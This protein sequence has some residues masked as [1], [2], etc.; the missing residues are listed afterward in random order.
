MNKTLRLFLKI[1]LVLAAVILGWNARNHAV[2]TLPVDYDEDDYIRAAQEYTGVFRSGNLINL[3]EYNYRPEH[4]PLA[5]IIFG[6]SLLTAPEKPLTP[7]RATTSSPDS[8]LSRDLLIPARTISALEGTLTVFFLALIN[9][10]AGVLLASHTFTIKYTSQVML[11][12]LPSLTSFLTILAYLRFKKTTRKYWLILSALFLGLTAASKYIYCL[13]G[14]AIL[15]DW[16]L[17]AYK[18]NQLKKSFFNAFGWGLISIIFFFVAN[19]YLWVDPLSRL[20]ESIFFHAAYSTTASEVQSAG[21]PIWQPFIWLSMSPKEWHPMVFR[22]APDVYISILAVLGFPRLWKKERLYILWLIVAILFLLAWPTK[23]PQYILVLTVP[24]SL[25]AAEGLY[26]VFAQPFQRWWKNRSTNQTTDIPPKNEINRAAKW[27]IPGL[28]AFTLLTIFPLIFQFAVSLTDFSAAS[29]RDGFTGGIWREVLGGLT[30]QIKPASFDLD[31]RSNF[32]RFVGLSSF[33]PVFNYVAS[34]GILFFNVM[35]MILSVLLQTLL[36]VVCAL[37]LWQKDLRLGKF[38]QAI[39][40]LP[41]AIPE[42]IGAYFWLNIFQPAN[43][44]LALAVTQYGANIP[45]G[46]LNGWQETANLW[47]LIYLIAALWYGFPFMMLAASAGLKMISPEVLEAAKI[48]GANRWQTFQFILW[49]LLQP[50]LLPAIIIRAIFSFNQFYLFQVFYF[51]NSTLATF[52]YNVFNPS[53]FMRNGGSF[54]LSAV[55]NIIAVI[56][57]AGLVTVFNRYSQAGRGL[58]NV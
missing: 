29:I 35:W 10:L 9:P 2:Q 49:P 1:I 16:F 33:E 58:H 14:F 25:A 37:L 31:T 4:P 45:F 5:K 13:V 57:L 32:V 8:Y 20:Y 44:W 30:G 23:W 41:W 28:I 43:G 12:A 6:A 3:T 51:P 46:F 39:F 27:L 19:P 21:F 17:D 24:L 55:I 53:G 15:I 7:D 18:K 22:F 56:M 34:Q 42:M 40:I 50:L 38:W 48:D 52:S 36:G 54:A 26:T 47:L 11:E